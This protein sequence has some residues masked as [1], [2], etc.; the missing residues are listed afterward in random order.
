[1]P[2]VGDVHRKDFVVVSEDETGN[3]FST[4]RGRLDVDGRLKE[5]S[6]L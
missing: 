1:M 4:G 2:V 6:A 5:T 3:V